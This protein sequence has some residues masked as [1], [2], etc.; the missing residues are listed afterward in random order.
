MSTPAA[1]KSRTAASSPFF[2]A[3]N[4]ASEMGADLPPLL[5]STE[6]MHSGVAEPQLCLFPTSPLHRYVSVHFSTAWFTKGGR[7]FNACLLRGRYGGGL[8]VA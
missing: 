6:A 3:S 7:A 1:S 8:C 2:I 4:N 5:P